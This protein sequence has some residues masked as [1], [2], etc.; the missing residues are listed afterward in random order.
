MK[1]DDYD[2]LS[3]NLRVGKLSVSYNC[4]RRLQHTV[5]SG[6]NRTKRNVQTFYRD[7][8]W[9]KSKLRFVTI[10]IYALS[11]RKKACATSMYVSPGKSKPR[12]WNAGSSLKW[13]PPVLQMDM[14]KDSVFKRRWTTLIAVRRFV[15]GNLLEDINVEANGKWKETVGHEVLNAMV[16]GIVP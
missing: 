11:F 6:P 1:K 3:A 9:S 8:F 2:R 10:W 15:K 14:M 4:G 13:M 12:P 7:S 5:V 16:R